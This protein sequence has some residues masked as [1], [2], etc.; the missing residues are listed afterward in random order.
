MDQN[1]S[2]SS[3]RV[4]RTLWTPSAIIF[5]IQTSSRSKEKRKE[6]ERD[7]GAK[8][9]RERERENIWGYWKKIW[10]IRCRER[11]NSLIK[12]NWKTTHTL[13]EASFCRVSTTFWSARNS[14][15]SPRRSLIPVVHPPRASSFR[16][17]PVNDSSRIRKPRSLPL[18]S[19]LLLYALEREKIWPANMQQ[20]E[21][22]LPWHWRRICTCRLLRRTGCSS[23][24]LYSVSFIRWKRDSCPRALS[25]PGNLNSQFFLSLPRR[26]NLLDPTLKLRTFFDSDTRWLKFV[27]RRT[28]WRWFFFSPT[29]GEKQ[30]FLRQIAAGCSNRLE[31]RK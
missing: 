18:L 24:H 29:R 4:P 16:F 26:D 27:I 8:R 31:T 23:G 15:K 3:P 10:E 28:H 17:A 9:E 6:E 11:G 1:S 19:D 2:S 7:R 20:I 22:K 14:W 5:G 30:F 25:N 13:G 21:T 12:L